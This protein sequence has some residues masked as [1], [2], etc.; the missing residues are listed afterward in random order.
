M[1]KLLER[2]FNVIYPVL[3]PTYIQHFLRM[4][5]FRFPYYRFA[6]KLDYRGI[7]DFSVNGKQLYMRSHNTPIDMF[8][9]WYGIFGYWESTQLRLWSYLVA[10]YK[11][12][13]VLDV[14]ANSGVY[15]LIATTNAM[16]KV[17]AFE[18]VEA[19]RH[20]LEE[21]VSLNKG[22]A[23]TV[24]GELVG[25]HVGRESIFIPRAGWVDVAS[26]DSE[27]ARQ[28]VQEGTLTEVVCDMVTID[29]VLEREQIPAG[30]VILAKIDVEGAEERVLAGMQQTL[31]NWTYL[32]TAELLTE[33]VFNNFYKQVSGQYRCYAI[34]EQKSSVYEVQR[35]Q[36]HVTNYLFVPV[37]FDF[38]YA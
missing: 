17:H 3:K 1:K 36:V 24:H 11:P 28:F 8:I 34:D 22:A 21:N 25:D 35:F 15:S 20:M 7:V 12:H 30:V 4:I 31:K 10:T 2:I 19:V 16:S 37:S 27:F 32:F 6:E 13:T 5:G 23:V 18:P 29:H 38:H 14:G 9:F 33:S 26:V